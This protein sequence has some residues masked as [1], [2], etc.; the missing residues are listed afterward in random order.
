MVRWLQP[1]RSVT[2][3]LLL[4]APEIE[5]YDAFKRNRDRTIAEVRRVVAKRPSIPAAA[6][7]I[8]AAD[9]GGPVGDSADFDVDELLERARR[10]KV[11]G[12]IRT[13]DAELVSARLVHFTGGHWAAFSLGRRVDVVPNDRSEDPEQTSLQRVEV[14]VL[15][16]GNQVLMV[17]GSN[18]DVLRHAADAELKPGIREISA[19]WKEALRRHA[20]GRGSSEIARELA[21]VGCRR[22]AQT[23][24]L[25]LSDDGLIGPHEGNEDVLS[26]IVKITRDVE[27]GRK[28]DDCRAAISLVRQKHHEIGRRLAR[29]VMER[30]AELLKG[31]K[32]IADAIELEERLLLLTV[33][34]IDRESVKVP[35]HRLNVLE[36]A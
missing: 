23:I 4:Y 1:P 20:E 18:R 35:P 5:W 12:T 33:D 32:E 3:D 17:R 7:A 27:F 11:L 2:T 13:G 10:D 29:R 31:D 16:P 25:W 28:V 15:Q 26:A 19:V 8:P 9:S 30:A 21:A 6:I 24:R 36:E 34:S 22:T 14:S